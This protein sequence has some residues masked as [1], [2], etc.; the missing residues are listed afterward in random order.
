MKILVVSQYFPPEPGAPSNRVSAYVE[1]M[2]R[3]GHKVTVICEF[4]CYPSGILQKSDKWKLFRKEKKNNYTILRTYVLTFPQKNN[5]KRMLFYISFAISSFLAI[6]FIRRR[7]LVLASSPPIFFAYSSMI[8]AKIKRSK[9]AVDIRDLWPDTAKEVEAVSSRR[10]MKW[11]AVMERGLYRNATNI[12]T[13]SEGIKEKIEQRGGAGKTSVVYNGSFEQILNW[14]GAVDE[15]RSRLG[16]KDQIVITYAGI[17]G[18]GQDI[19]AVLPQ[20]IKINRR[21]VIIVFIGEGPHKA[22]LKHEVE[23][24]GAKH[25]QF[26]EPMSQ[27][28]VIP[29]LYAS[30]ILM[31]ILREIAFFGSA[32]PSKFFDS[33]AVGKPVIANVDGEMRKIMDQYQTG[34]YFSAGKDGSFGEA[35]EKL[36]G[37]AEIRHTMGANG[38][39]LVEE[40]FLRSKI[41]ENAVLRLENLF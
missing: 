2:A 31:V 21:D 37:N 30:D 5:I 4:P 20:L 1:A 26:F 38:K 32:I 17:I 22:E 34:L 27:A 24:A 15:L 8:A 28:D 33:M 18:L 9:F 19:K 25:I 35:V 12:S 29:Y 14:R 41:A 36:L 7:D 23:S 40:Q 6:L 16:W 3:R 11:G 39:K 13:V 10:L